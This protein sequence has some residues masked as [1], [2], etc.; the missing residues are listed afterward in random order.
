M[1]T[2]P[3]FIIGTDAA[4]QLK[5]L[6][7]AGLP[8]AGP[9]GA[10]VVA[11]L[12]PHPRAAPVAASGL[13]VALIGDDPQGMGALARWANDTGSLVIAAFD[14]ALVMEGLPKGCLCLASGVGGLPDLLAVVVRLLFQDGGMT[15]AG[16]RQLLANAGSVRCVRR[17]I[18]SPSRTALAEALL[19]AQERAPDDCVAQGAAIVN[20][21][22]DRLAG[23]RP[24]RR[25]AGWGRVL[26]FMHGPHWADEDIKGGFGAIT[27]RGAWAGVGIRW[28][29][30]L[31]LPGRSLKRRELVRN[32]GYGVFT[33]HYWGQAIELATGRRLPTREVCRVRRRVTETG[34]KSFPL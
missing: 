6:F 28:S 22:R 20:Q 1:I 8:A 2:I 14:R 25:R 7:P 11:R 3:L 4:E 16:L 15:V 32:P 19:A 10:F 13:A 30:S 34:G 26:T 12:P 17:I 5:H 21:L 27:L 33:E 9:R 24:C 23:R 29:L 18:P 31:G